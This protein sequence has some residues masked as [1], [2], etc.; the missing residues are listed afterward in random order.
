MDGLKQGGCPPL[1]S[2]SAGGAGQPEPGGPQPVPHPGK[3]GRA[4]GRALGHLLVLPQDPA[5]SSSSPPGSYRPYDEGLRR[6]VFITN[7]TG[8]PLIGKVG[9]F[10]GAWGEKAGVPSR[11]R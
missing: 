9:G 4:Q 11:G 6:K 2:P 10:L 3:E 1:P 5:I 7:E 8:Q